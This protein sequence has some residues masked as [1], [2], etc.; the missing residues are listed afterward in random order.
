MNKTRLP[1]I[2]ALLSYPNIHITTINVDSELVEYAKN[3]PTSDW[4]SERTMFKKSAF[5][6]YHMNDFLKALT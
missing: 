6:N 4:V 1:Y 2:D 5:L 3:S